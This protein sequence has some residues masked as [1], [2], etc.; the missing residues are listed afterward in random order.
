MFKYKRRLLSAVLAAVMF[1]QLAPLMEIAAY[2]ET[3][4]FSNILGGETYHSVE[5]SDLGF[6][7]LVQDGEA[8]VMPEAPADEGME[9]I[10]WFQGESGG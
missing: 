5:F 3:V 2:A 6:T 7:Q 10:G 1:L 9:F 4:I 8:L